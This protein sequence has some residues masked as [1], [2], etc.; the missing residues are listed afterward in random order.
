MPQLTLGV[1]KWSAKVGGN[2]HPFQG[3]G[4]VFFMTLLQLIDFQ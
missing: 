1:L 3:I 2:I 4:Q